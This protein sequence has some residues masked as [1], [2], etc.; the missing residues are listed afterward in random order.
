MVYIP[1][2]SAGMA[3]AA[4]FLPQAGHHYAVQRNFDFGPDAQEAPWRSNVSNLSPWLRHRLIREEDILRPVLEHHGAEAAEKFISEI[5]WRGYFKG[6]LE[7]RPTMWRDYTVDRDAALSHLASNSG[8]RKTY[9]AAIEGRTGIEAYD[10]FAKELVATN[11]LHN[12]AR[13][14]FASIWIFTLKLPW[15]LGADF[16]LQHLIDGDAASNSCSWRW[17]GGLHTQGKTYLARADNIAKYTDG[18]LAAAGLAS[19]AA[20]LADPRSYVP[21]QSPSRDLAPAHPYVLLLH[22]EDCQAETLELATP[23]IAVIQLNMPDP[24]SPVHVA[25]A[26]QKFAQGALDDAGN[27]AAAHWGCPLL[28]WSP[29]G[30]PLQQMV[31]QTGAQAAAMAWLPTGSL[32]DALYAHISGLAVPLARIVRRYDAETWPY[33]TKGFFHLR[34]KSAPMLAR[35]SPPDL[36]SNL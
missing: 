28:H 8:L 20:P 15:V 23:P 17:V 19:F 21:G 1:T 36:L 24:R 14:W 32:K 9:D 16:L 3:H 29:Q 25:D 27:R 31:Q 7:L 26:V 35:L 5:L 13:M 30:T 12:H 18:R 22:S 10:A 33:A 4:K 11:Y 2:H 34:Q 6:W